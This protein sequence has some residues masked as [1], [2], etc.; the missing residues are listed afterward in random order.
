MHSLKQT[1]V[2]VGKQKSFSLESALISNNSRD[3]R[4][5]FKADIGQPSQALTELALDVCVR[6]IDHVDILVVL[7]AS[8]IGS[9]SDV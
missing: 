3:W 4:Q 9:S 1:K 7:G 5:F 2:D 8:S 6:S